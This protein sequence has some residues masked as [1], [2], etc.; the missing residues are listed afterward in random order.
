MD[1]Q[2]I[3]NLCRKR[4]GGVKGLSEAIGMTEQ[5]LHRCIRENNIQA[6]DLEKIAAVLNVNIGYFFGENLDEKYESKG[7]YALA[8]KEFK[9]E[10][11]GDSMADT[12][13]ED[14]TDIKLDEVVLP[15]GSSDETKHTVEKM[16][17]EIDMLRKLLASAEKQLEEKE[18]LIN[19]LMERK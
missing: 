15:S 9:V 4:K 14:I 12:Q 11:L 8:G 1:L 5:N 10:H 3:K 17:L 2:L 18:R 13:V 16:S 6:L 19:L 7:K